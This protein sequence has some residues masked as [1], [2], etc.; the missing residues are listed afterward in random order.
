[1]GAVVALRLEAKLYIATTIPT[2]LAILKFLYDSNA[3]PF[4][5]YSTDWSNE[6]RAASFGP[7]ASMY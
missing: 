3:S 1:M 2:R 6:C 4:V 7:T 5:I